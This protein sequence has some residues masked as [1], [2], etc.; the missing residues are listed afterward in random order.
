MKNSIYIIIGLLAVLSSC[1]KQLN[2][3]PVS[4]LATTNF[5]SNNN[6]FLQAVNGAYYQLRAYPD[7]TLWL[8]EMRSDNINAVSDGNRDW[9]GINT[10]SPNIT[11]VGFISSAWKNNFN[12]IY[13]ANTVLDALSTKGSVIGSSALVTRYTAECRF[14]RAFYYFNLVKLFGK[15]PLVTKPLTAD[16][17]NT[18]QR[19][20]VADV[21]TQIISDLQYAASNLPASYTGSDIGRATSY[22]AKGILG[23]V[24]LTRSGPTYSVEGPGLNSNEYDKALS[25]FNEII[26]SNQY[27][28]LPD[29][30]SIFS[31]TNENNK[32]VL[33]DV[34]YASS[35][36]GASFPS[37]LVP[38]AYW[39]SLGISNTYGNGYGSSSFPVTANLKNSY[40]VGTV[41]GTDVRYPFNV[42]TTYTKSPFIKKYIDISKKGTSGTDWPINFIVLRYTDILLMKA[43]CIL[44]GAAGTQADVDGIVNQV[45][46]RAGV[47]ALSNVTLNTL[48]EERRREFVGE[49]LRW[50]D[51][52]REGLAVTTMNAWIAGDAITTISAVVPNYI[53]Y[54]VPATEIQTKAGLYT[55]NPGYN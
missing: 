15:V 34:Q 24:Y 43:E 32:E 16:E 2:Q 51:L 50:N 1:S 27:S 13:N 38:V 44:H 41:S 3:Q 8:S 22:A 54:P 30:A 52:V 53:I 25:V 33:F 45:R 47:G 4:S 19:S 17:V 29:Y 5:Y 55:Q 10:F 40:T 12:G 39:T 14:L 20:P 18:V 6:D 46:A 7:Q 31:Y 23:Q 9:D 26:A 36:D 21:Y 37:D 28:F 48:I 42:A 35:I 11:T 49:G